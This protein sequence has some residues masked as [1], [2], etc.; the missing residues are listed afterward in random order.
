M[1]IW[2]WLHLNCLMKFFLWCVHRFKSLDI[3]W[4]LSQ[5]LLSIKKK[6]DSARNFVKFL[7]YVA[8]SI[9]FFFFNGI[10]SWHSNADIYLLEFNDSHKYFWIGNLSQIAHSRLPLSPHSLSFYSLWN[11]IA[12]CCTLRLF[13]FYWICFFLVFFFNLFIGI[14]L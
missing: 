7:F 5:V 8:I 13:F 6:E 1:K 10:A 9:I 12:F 3:L 4:K 14:Q 11:F 2:R